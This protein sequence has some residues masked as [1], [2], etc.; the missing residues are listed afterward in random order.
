MILSSCSGIEGTQQ[1]IGNDLMDRIKNQQEQQEPCE[2]DDVT[3][4]QEEDELNGFLFVF[5]SVKLRTMA[6]I[7]RWPHPRVLAEAQEPNEAH[8]PNRPSTHTSIHM[9]GP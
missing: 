7:Y 9:T 4:N 5:H 3:T 1:E 8:H 6:Y 2:E